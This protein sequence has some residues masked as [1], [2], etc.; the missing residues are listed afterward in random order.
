MI[1]QP[2]L[3]TYFMLWLLIL[4]LKVKKFILGTISNTPGWKINNKNSKINI[5]IVYLSRKLWLKIGSHFLKT[6]Y[7]LNIH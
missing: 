7:K 3:L 6:S 4:L 1:S 5:E 2:E